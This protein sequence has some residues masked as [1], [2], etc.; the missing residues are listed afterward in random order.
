[1]VSPSVLRKYQFP[2]IREMAGKCKERGIP[3]LYHSD[4]NVKE[5]IPELINMGVCALH[6]LEPIAVDIYEIKKEYGDRLCLIGNI[7]LGTVLVTGTVEEIIEDTKMHIQR[8]ATGGGYC[9]GSSNS[10]TYDVPIENYRAMID[11]VMEFG[12]YPICV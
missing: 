10:I 2:F 8:L 11:T 12:R 4:G 3:F 6:P 5:I 9:L 1:M 7:D